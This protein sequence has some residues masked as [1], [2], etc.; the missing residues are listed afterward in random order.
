VV[1]V[2]GVA[3]GKGVVLGSVDYPPAVL[4]YY[5]VWLYSIRPTQ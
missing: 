5:I 4:L 2:G 1:K 3:G